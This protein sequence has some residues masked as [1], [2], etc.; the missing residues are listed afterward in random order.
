VNT[1]RSEKRQKRK[2]T[3]IP[4]AEVRNDRQQ[5]Q[6]TSE[7]S[8]EIVNDCNRYFKVFKYILYIGIYVS[9]VVTTRGTDT[10]GATDNFVP[11]P[12]R[13]IDNLGTVR[14]F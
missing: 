14:W 3:G 7:V 8:V 13:K 2:T 9:G 1:D 12:T 4:E 11:R 10:C 6:Q 5:V